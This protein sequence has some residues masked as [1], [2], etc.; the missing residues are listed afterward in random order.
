MSVTDFELI[1]KNIDVGYIKR[2]RLFNFGEPLLHPSLPDILTRIKTSSSPPVRTV[3]ISTNA[4]HH[5]FPML[6]E[7]FKT[8]VLDLLAVSC[9]GDATKEEYERLRPP[10]RYE[11]LIEFL[12]KTKELRDRYAP[13][14]ILCTSNICETE[15]GK[16]R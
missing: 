3:E 10:G 1:M 13:N 15:E 14:M 12:T 16:K 5:D 11:K 6:A 4:Q 8:G 7:I 9:D 2:L